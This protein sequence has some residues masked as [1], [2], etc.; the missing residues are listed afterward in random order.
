VF[1][2]IV[3]LKGDT[4]MFAKLFLDHPKSVNEGY[5]EHARFALLFA[6]LL[7]TAALAAFVHAIIPQHAKRRP[8]RLCSGFLKNPKIEASRCADG[9]LILENLF[10]SAIF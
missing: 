6:I 1:E 5:F 3:A 7:M 10:I 9:R 2:Y 4:V 8:V